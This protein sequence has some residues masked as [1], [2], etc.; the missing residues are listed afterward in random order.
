MNSIQIS[1]PT[2]M[3]HPHPAK[4]A[5]QTAAIVEPEVLF[6]FLYLFL[7]RGQRPRGTALKIERQSQL[8]WAR[9]RC[10]V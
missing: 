6:L 8:A 9:V 10:G 1:L 5:S 3:R 7:F 4:G 2:S